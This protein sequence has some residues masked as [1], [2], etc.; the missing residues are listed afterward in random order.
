MNIPFLSGNKEPLLGVDIGSTSLKLVELAR[1]G[2]SYQVVSA[3][4]HPLP[5]NSII[6]GKIADVPALA[7]ALRK[8]VAISRSK[9]KRVALAVPGSA[10]ITRVIDMPADLKD[11]ELETQL[12]MEAEQYIPYSLDEVAVDFTRISE[13]DE[14]TAQ[15]KVLLAACRKEAIE[16]LTDLA[17][18][19]DLKAKIIDVEPF[20]LERVYPFLAE[21]LEQD[22]NGLIAVVD[23]GAS[24]LRVNVLDR[25]S[26]VYSREEMFGTKQ[27]N[28]EIQR[29]YGLSSEEALAAQ[30]SGDLPSD[31][32]DEV[33]QP[34]QNSLLQQISRSLQFFYSST[35]YSHLDCMILAGGI[36]DGEH[37]A[38]SAAARLDLPVV[39]A[40]PF[41]QMSLHS[42]V[43]REQLNRMAPSLLIATG[44]ALRGVT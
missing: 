22:N 31:F 8:A 27:L 7:Q 23:C 1:S 29:R 18:Q 10:V 13:A 39:A 38:Q 37:L 36:V 44:L 40:N 15:V 19:A 25:G 2:R 14:K 42:T 11:D 35:S 3:V 4:V 34:F 30:R 28:E 32:R 21:Q 9:A 33:L 6:E 12:L 17:E 26:T 43:D 41:R 16:I 24:T 5:P 20:C